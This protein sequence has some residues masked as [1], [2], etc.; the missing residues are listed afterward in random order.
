VLGPAEV[1]GDLCR[2]GAP[3]AHSYQSANGQQRISE[4][5]L[6]F[7]CAGYWCFIVGVLVLYRYQRR[8]AMVG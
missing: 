5:L 4:R 7:Y 3:A 1:Y 2:H 6:V 8:P